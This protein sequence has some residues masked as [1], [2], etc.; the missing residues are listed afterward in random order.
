MTDV[1]RT[2]SVDGCDRGGKLARGMCQLHYKRWQTHGD[3]SVTAY[4]WGVNKSTCKVDGCARPAHAKGYCQS[5][6]RTLAP[7]SGGCSVDGCDNSHYARGLCG[8]H[9]ARKRLGRSVDGLLQPRNIVRDV[10]MSN[11]YVR[12]MGSGGGYVHRLVMA[13][14]LGRPLLKSENVHHVNGVR[15]DNRIENLELWTKSQPAG[16]RV[17]DKVAWAREILALYGDT[18]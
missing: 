14:H 11:G 13:E 2:C 10:I 5:H 18:F 8:G 7:P 9:Y 6:Y 1:E 4:T 16:Q 15:D 17:A 12:R 3:A